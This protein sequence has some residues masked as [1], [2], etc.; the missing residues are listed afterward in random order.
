MPKPFSCHVDRCGCVICCVGG[1]N[2]RGGAIGDTGADAA[3]VCWSNGTCL[4]WNDSRLIN[5]AS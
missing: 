2:G 1:D 3:I 5:L 4:F